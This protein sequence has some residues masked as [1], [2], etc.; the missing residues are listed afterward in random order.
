MKENESKGKSTRTVKRITASLY[1]KGYLIRENGKR[2][3]IWKI[4][5]R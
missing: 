5:E 3:G 2:N 4:I 1:E